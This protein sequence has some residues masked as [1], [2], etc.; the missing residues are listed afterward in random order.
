MPQARD[1]LSRL[2]KPI[3]Q[4]I[5]H[6]LKWL[7]QNFDDLMHERLSGEFRGFYRLRVGSYRVIYT[8]E[9]EEHQ[10]VIHLIG[11][12]RDIYKR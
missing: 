9:Q 7:S 6:K 1:D 4:R 11:H 8:V 2:D 5:L 10:F 12:R 3:A